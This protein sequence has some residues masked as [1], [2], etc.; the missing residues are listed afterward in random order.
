[1]HFS[2]L[3]VLQT[4]DILMS[5][6]QSFYL[7]TS[8]FPG[9]WMPYK[10]SSFFKL[11]VGAL[12]TGLVVQWVW[13]ATWHPFLLMSVMETET[14]RYERT[15]ETVRLVLSLFLRLLRKLFNLCI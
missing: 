9:G 5:L 12:T 7:H 13:N 3:I 2:T 14:D 8:L 1:M 11:F 6:N 4:E 10:L 15:Q